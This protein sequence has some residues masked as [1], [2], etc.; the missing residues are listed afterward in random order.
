MKKLFA[1]CLLALALPSWATTYFFSDCASGSDPACVAGANGN[2]GTVSTSPKQN[3]T[4][5]NYAGLAAGDQLKFA[6]GGAWSITSAITLNN[7]ANNSATSWATVNPIVLDSYTP[8]WGPGTAQP[9]MSL[10]S[11]SPPT[12]IFT[13][14][15]G[16][17]QGLTIQNIKFTATG[18]NVTSSF[19]VLYASSRAN[20]ITFQN[21][22]V[23][24]IGTALNIPAQT[25]H[26]HDW[27]ILGNAFKNSNSMAL[28]V[29]ADFTRIAGNTFLNNAKTLNNTDHHIYLA[30][31]VTPSGTTNPRGCIG[32]AV[33]DNYIED[34]SLNPCDSVMI[35]Q[36]DLY[37]GLHISR[38]TLIQSSGTAGGP[39]Y[40]VQ[41]AAGNFLGD[42]E[43]CQGCVVN[44]N[45]VVNV[46]YAALDFAQCTDCK[47]FNNTIVN[48]TA[49]ES[50]GIRAGSVANPFHAG[51][52]ISTRFLIYN[53]SI[54]LPASNTVD[55]HGIE[56]SRDGTGNV[57]VGNVV[58]F[59]SGSAGTCL[60]SISLTSSAFAEWDYNLCYDTTVPTWAQFNSVLYATR[61]AFSVAVGLDG[62]SLTSNP[63]LTAT[64]AA[65]NGWS[66]AVQNGSPVI[67][68]C[69]SARCSPLGKAGRAVTGTRDIG[70]EEK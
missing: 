18:G 52:L 48:T 36:H 35:V 5:F 37:T 68:A 70:S 16:G 67:D 11:A 55:A 13:M 3:L 23:D 27:M 32:V 59:A 28:L 22:T 61:S 46:G 62:N 21:N 29:T 7:T 43:G 57:V 6:K 44:D 49:V 56:L 51:D 38:N 66:M 25:T 50:V 65:G 54:Y 15:S 42:I 2:L 47:V 58:D 1:L 63:L 26:S 41:L 20:Y 31:Q 19:G 39:C 8:A 14:S 10:D 4:G 60:Y 69:A 53:N 30:C 64:P 33:E 34:N 9:I 45:T 24:G 12:Q 40:G 17:Q